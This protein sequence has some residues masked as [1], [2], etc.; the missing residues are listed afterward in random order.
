MKL[1]RHIL[2]EEFP[3][4]KAGIQERAKCDPEFKMKLN[5]YNTLD[6]D[7]LHFETDR[8]CSDIHLED[9]KKQRVNLKDTL[10]RL[11]TCP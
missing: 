3:K 8:A 11:L 2:A 5:E 1:D 4:L 7:I 6:K 10:Y 9:L